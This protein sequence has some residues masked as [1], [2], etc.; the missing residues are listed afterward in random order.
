MRFENRQHTAGT[1]RVHRLG[2]R[3]HARALRTHLKLPICRK[4]VITDAGCVRQYRPGTSMVRRGST[5]RVR[6]RACTKCLQIS[7][8]VLS[9]CRTRGHETDTSAVRATQRVVSRRLVTHVPRL[10]VLASFDEIP[11]QGGSPLPAERAPDPLPLER[12][13]TF[14]SI[15]GSAKN[16]RTTL[17]C[18]IDFAGFEREQVWSPLTSSKVPTEKGDRPPPGL[19]RGGAAAALIKRGVSAG[20]SQRFALADEMRRAHL[21]IERERNV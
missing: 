11:G 8:L 20:T 13:S 10:E 1:R 9:A 4:N 14:E 7:T 17:V 3:G 2:T 16:P 5:V 21:A 15:R 19:R 18:R 12:G 6:Q